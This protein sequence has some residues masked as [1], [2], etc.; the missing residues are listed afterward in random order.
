MAG[1]DDGDKS[2]LNYGLYPAGGVLLG[3]LIGSWL[4]RKF[5]W[6]SVGLLSGAILGLVAGMYLLIKDALRINKK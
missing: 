6:G 4:D 3:L 2:A 5:G 1:G